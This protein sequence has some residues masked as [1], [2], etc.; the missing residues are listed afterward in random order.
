MLTPK[1]Q[2]CQRHKYRNTIYFLACRRRQPLPMPAARAARGKNV[3]ADEARRENVHGD[4]R[5]DGSIHPCSLSRA[6]S[7]GASDPESEIAVVGQLA[8]SRPNAIA[9]PA[10]LGL[11]LGRRPPCNFYKAG[12]KPR[13]ESKSLILFF[14]RGGRDR[15]MPIA[16]R[17]VDRHARYAAPILFVDRRTATMALVCRNRASET[18]HE[19]H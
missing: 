12:V 13:R 8:A 4:C 16:R 6:S 7:T 3:Q 2:P 9:Y 15:G 14:S 19:S 10:L 17:P 18:C 11:G 5:V 1:H